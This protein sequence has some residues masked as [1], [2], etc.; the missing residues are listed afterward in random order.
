MRQRIDAERGVVDEHRAPQVP[1]N[2]TGPS[3]TEKAETGKGDGRRQLPSVQP[4]QLG[5]ARQIGNLRQVG[6][7]VSASE[8]PTDMAVEKPVLPRRMDVLL[9][10]RMQVVLAVLGSPPKN[11]LLGTALS[12]ES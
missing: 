9:G 3:P 5:I 1:Y 10:I 2:E 11:A 6:P 7:I 12:E 8:N 4:D